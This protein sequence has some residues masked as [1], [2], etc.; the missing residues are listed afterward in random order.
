MEFKKSE[1]SEIRESP[2]SQVHIQMAD[3]PSTQIGAESD[4]IDAIP[5][6][7]QWSWNPVDWF[8]GTS[9]LKQAS[10]TS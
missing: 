8:T 1:F 4:R 2:Q 10:T 9:H 3:A 5:I 7:D 6:D